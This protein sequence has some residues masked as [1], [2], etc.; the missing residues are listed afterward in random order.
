[1]HTNDGQKDPRDLSKVNC[2]RCQK[3]AHFAKKRPNGS[4][5]VKTH[6][7]VNAKE[8]TNDNMDRLMSSLKMGTD[9]D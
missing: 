6:A 5:T 9:A 2:F 4:K 1:M 3:F 7:S 8:T